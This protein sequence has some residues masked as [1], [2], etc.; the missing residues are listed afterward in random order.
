MIRKLKISDLEISLDVKEKVE[1]K[2]IQKRAYEALE[3]GLSIKDRNYNI[4]ISAPN[5]LEIENQVL[6]IVESFARK[7]KAPNDLFYVHNF[8]NPSNPISISLESERGDDFI[9]D[10]EKLIRNVKHVL[11]ELFESETLNKQKEELVSQY[12]RK[13]EEL[14]N[15]LNKKAQELGFIIQPI[16]QNIFNIIPVLAGEPLTP[17][18]YNSLSDDMKAYIDKKRI[19]LEE[20]ISNTLRE[21]NKLEKELREKI[22]EMEKIA[23]KNSIKPYFLELENKYHDCV[24]V[25]NFL[26]DMEEDISNNFQIFLTPENQLPPGPLNPFR[27][28]KVNRIVDNKELEGAPVIYERNPTYYNLI[29][30]IEKEAF[31]GAFVTDVSNIISGSLHLA[32]GG[33]IIINAYELLKDPFAYDVLKR[34]IKNGEIV[35]EDIGERLSLFSTKSLR[36]EPIQFNAKI[37]LI[38]DNFLYYLLEM[39]DNDFRKYFNVLVDFETEIE[40]DIGVG[41]VLE[42]IDNL[43]KEKNLLDFTENAK[44]EIIRHL[45]RFSEDKK[46]IPLNTKLINDILLESDYIAKRNGLEFV[47]ETSVKQAIKNKMFRHSKV[48]E[49]L[50][51]FIKRGILMFDFEGKRVGVVN[52]LSVISMPD[53]SFGIP[54]RISASVGLGKAGIIDIEKETGLGGKIHT[55]AVLIIGGYI[56]EKYGRE[57][58]ISL[59][60]RITF[61]QNYSGVEGDS[62]SVAELLA[63][64]SAISEVPIKQN[65]AITG[66]LNQKGEVQPVGGIVEK[67]E[68]FY[69]SLKIMGLLN[70][71]CGVIVPSRNMDNIIL[72]DEILEAVKENKFN[73]WTVDNFDDVIEIATELKANEFHQRVLEKL[74]EFHKK[75]KDSNSD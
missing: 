24:K 46:K 49:K 71:N 8:K 23:V 30:R 14:I 20:F 66:S 38:G 60:A 42:Y 15:E 69:H 37:I 5:W 28:Y 50:R 19:Q 65:I 10:I 22:E 73:I 6:K 32:N 51:E 33:Y 57:I 75:L 74:K 26:R 7:E 11:K 45:L 9:N 47:D 67:I 44:L 31:M 41:F 29:G 16:Q 62:A 13:K 52:G 35:I 70:E 18:K 55:K 53:Y 1:L 58:P 59:H 54:S 34:V 25:L 48:E 43:K 12:N 36:P 39:Y 61:E 68:G 17:Q 40:Q 64:L 2:D 21:I 3:F 72:S 56:I 4:F 63:I 27:K